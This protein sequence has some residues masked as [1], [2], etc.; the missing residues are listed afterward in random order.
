MLGDGFVL[1]LIS[2]LTMCSVSV[3]D[4][5]AGDLSDLKTIALTLKK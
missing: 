5:G 4:A 1:V 3:D 2:F